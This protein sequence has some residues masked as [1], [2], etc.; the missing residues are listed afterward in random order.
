MNSAPHI[1][2]LNNRFVNLVLIVEPNGLTLIDTGLAGSGPKL[3][4]SQLAALG[5]QPSDLKRILFTHADPDHTGGA[6]ALRA[7]TGAKLYASA[8]EKEAIERGTTSRQPT[9]VVFNIF[10]NTLGKL[11]MPMSPITA[12]RVPSIS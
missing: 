12:K 10:A 3:V 4:L 2:R 5:F 8:I 11:M 1:H 6:T 9:S 7:A